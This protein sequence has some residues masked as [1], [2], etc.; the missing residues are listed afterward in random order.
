MI[1]EGGM[2]ELCYHGWCSSPQKLHTNASPGPACTH[3]SEDLITDGPLPSNGVGVIV[4]GNKRQPLSDGAL[5]GGG[6]VMECMSTKVP[7]G[8][9][10]HRLHPESSS[11]V[12]P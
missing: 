11:A 6:G 3:L 8:E 4:G 7:N 5:W 9:R 10:A 12:A 2:V 1:G